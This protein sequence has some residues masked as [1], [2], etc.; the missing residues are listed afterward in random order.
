[1]SLMNEVMMVI[2]CEREPCEETAGGPG[3]VSRPCRTELTERGEP[4]Q[5]EAYVLESP[6]LLARPVHG[7]GDKVRRQMI[8]C[9]KERI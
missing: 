4:T 6:A 1:M 9:K 5:R 7:V 8:G 3:G 2:L